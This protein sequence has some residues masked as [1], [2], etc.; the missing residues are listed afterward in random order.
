MDKRYSARHQRRSDV[1]ERYVFQMR[2][3]SSS[4][5]SCSKRLHQTHDYVSFGNVCW[6]CWRHNQRH[7]VVM[8][9]H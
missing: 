2:Q 8:A 1:D 9:S 4:C 7:G 6:S 3:L 5:E